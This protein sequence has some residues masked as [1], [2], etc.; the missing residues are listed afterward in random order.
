MKNKITTF[1]FDIGNV[2][3][4]FD[5]QIIV[6]RFEK[7]SGMPAKKIYCSMFDPGFING[8][9]TGRISEKNFYKTVC[10][11]LGIKISFSQFREIFSNI[12][13][14]NASIYKLIK[15]LK[16]K[17]RICI[18]SNTDRT[19]FEYIQKRY[20]VINIF[21]S[22]YLSYKLNAM[23][24]ETRIFRTVLEGEKVKPKECVYTDDIKHNIIKANKLGINAIQ[25][26]STSQ[27]KK[28]LKKYGIN[29]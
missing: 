3:L 13:T 2:L 27:F 15:S 4:F 21:D 18:L 5:H 28:S 6:K 9:E 23:K 1:I 19:H 17:Y 20:P 26:K 29:L 14:P 10:A 16:G 12:F 25:F 7:L 22:Y 24:P 8:F 11:K